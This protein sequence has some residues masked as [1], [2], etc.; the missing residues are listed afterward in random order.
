MTSKDP[1]LL[2]YFLLPYLH[3]YLFLSLSFTARP[4]VSPERDGYQPSPP[5]CLPSLIL[6]S[7]SGLGAV[8]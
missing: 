1:D 7:D 6:I 2:V 8:L 4:S 3:P 5:V